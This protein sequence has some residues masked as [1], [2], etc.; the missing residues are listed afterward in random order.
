MKRERRGGKGGRRGEREGGEKG[1]SSA[2]RAEL[3]PWFEGAYAPYTPTEGGR[4]SLL[5]RLAKRKREETERDMRHENNRVCWL[6]PLPESGGTR[7][8]AVS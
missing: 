6:C 7:L 8:G 4:P 5:N 1:A 2:G 3:G